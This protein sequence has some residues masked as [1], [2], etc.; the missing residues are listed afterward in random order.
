VASVVITV[1][2]LD[3]MSRDGFPRYVESLAVL[4]ACVGLFTYA[5]IQQN[6]GQDAL[7]LSEQRFRDI[8]E[9]AGEFLWEVDAQG[10]YTYASQACRTMLDYTEDEIVGK[11][12]FYDLH[13]E[14][15]RD[16]FRRAAF[17]VFQRKGKFVDLH[18]RVVTKDGRV[19]D[20]LT[21]GVP[22]LGDD[23]RLLGY[24]GSDHN[25]TERKRAEDAL[26]EEASRRRLL[27][28]QSRDGI[29]VLDENGKVYEANQ[30]YAT[31]LGYSLAELQNL[32][33]W[34]WDLQWTP[35][36]LR[37][38]IRLVER[39][40]D[41]FETRHRRKDG[42]WYDVEISTS[43]ILCAGQKLILCICR[44]IS[45]RKE[46][47]QA[48]RQAKA[49]AEAANRAKSTFLTN[50]SHEI[51]TPMTAIL[52]FSDLLLLASLSEQKRLNCV[53]AI[54]R[55]GRALLELIN[56]ILD[57]SRVEAER[58]QLE[59]KDC[60]LRPIVDAVVSTARPL[61]DKQGLLLEV[62]YQPPLPETLHTDKLRLHQILMNLVGNAIKFT[63]QGTVQIEVR[64]V[65]ENHG[66]GRI[67]FA[68]SD[69]GIG[70]PADKLGELFT[71][72]MQVDESTSRR[73]G[74]TGLGLAISWRLA[75]ALGGRLTVSS[76]LGEGSTF[77]LILPAGS[78]PESSRRPACPVAVRES[79]GF[80]G[81]ELPVMQGRILLAEDDPDIQFVVAQFLQLMKLQVDIAQ[82]GR[83]ACQ[84]AQRSQAET[85][86]YDLIL[87][88][89]QMPDMDGYEATRYLRRHGWQG[90]IVALTAHA[91]LGD[92]ERCLAE[93]CN[94]YLAKPIELAQLQEVTS[95]YLSRGVAFTNPSG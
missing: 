59:K 57:L 41:F 48:L 27:F 42:T 9:A 68:V 34:D 25:I 82:D 38:Q 71:P 12:H 81:E 16:A 67:E 6:R 43:G 84:M 2:C 46:A 92:R 50:M 77:T 69:T 94:D 3:A 1:L 36:Q 40:G 17:E 62:D 15:G 10:R 60:P 28:E 53:E 24:R 37:E 85:A 32:H 70:I 63:E 89:I 26:A 5:L 49:A 58:L 64:Y 88:D 44:D 83:V 55:N 86:P 66:A 19:L 7:R 75:E 39:V 76:E 65:G 18:N 23:G 14:E 72:F 45:K 51:R 90:P 95:R 22:I 74:G 30:Q 78:L 33:V 87:M 13:P 29:V 79:E 61:A 20:V 93:G 11:L 4:A 21:N 31:M 52:G 80:S 54:R 8:G 47:E 56:G 73:Y 35:E 91:M